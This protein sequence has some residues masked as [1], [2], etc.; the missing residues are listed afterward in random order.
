VVIQSIPVELP[1]ERNLPTQTKPENIV[2]AVDKDGGVFWNNQA[3]EER[4]LLA[5]LKEIAVRQPQP[6]VHIRGDKDGRYE[7]VGRVVFACQ[8]AGILKIG[9]ITEPPPRN[10]SR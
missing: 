3:V 7:F 4:V 6:E 1:K 9:F 5:R 2:I 10:S 8:R